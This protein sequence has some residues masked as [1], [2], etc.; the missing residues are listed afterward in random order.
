MSSPPT[1]EPP[2]PLPGDGVD[3]TRRKV[4]FHRHANR[5]GVGKPSQL[6]HIH[7]LE[8]QTNDTDSLRQ[9]LFSGRSLPTGVIDSPTGVASNDDDPHRLFQLLRR[10]KKPSSVAATSGGGGGAGSSLTTFHSHTPQAPPLVAN[11]SLATPSPQPPVDAAPPTLESPSSGKPPP[12]RAAHS[13]RP[14]SATRNRASG[15]G[16]HRE[17][18]MSICDGRPCT[19]QKLPKHALDLFP[20]APGTHHQPSA[21]GVA[22]GMKDPFPQRPRRQSAP[23]IRGLAPHHHHQHGSRDRVDFGCLFVKGNDLDGFHEEFP[24]P[25]AQVNIPLIETDWFTTDSWE[26]V[27]PTE[28][29]RSASSTSGQRGDLGAEEELAQSLL[30]YELL[31]AQKT[32]AKSAATAAAAATGQPSFRR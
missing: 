3:D 15:G 2:P 28:A 22:S 10:R 20:D 24:V 31:V 19:R 30:L 23:S 21:S 9:A 8:Q 29:M 25:K 13:A 4:L 12:G 11:H 26:A 6:S 32:T 18:N 17:A 14:F 7:V 27:P 1:A 16:T 5:S